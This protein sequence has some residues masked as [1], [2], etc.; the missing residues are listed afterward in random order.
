MAWV[1]SAFLVR[2]I[3]ILRQVSVKI[4]KFGNSFPLVGVYFLENTYK[5]AIKR[6]QNAHVDLKITVTTTYYFLGLH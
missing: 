6:L 3:R 4:N 5:T 1:A 2:A